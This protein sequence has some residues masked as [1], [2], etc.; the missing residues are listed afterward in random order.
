M[1]DFE[2][3]TVAVYSF[4]KKR[5]SSRSECAT[6]TPNPST[7]RTAFSSSSFDEPR[8]KI[9]PPSAGS[10]PSKHTKDLTFCSAVITSRT[11]KTSQVPSVGSKLSSLIERKTTPFVHLATYSIAVGLTLTTNATPASRRRSCAIRA[12]DRPTRT[13]DGRSAKILATI[14]CKYS[15]S[16]RRTA[17]SELYLFSTRSY[18]IANFIS[19]TAGCR[20][21]LLIFFDVTFLTK[22][23]PEKYR[24]SECSPPVITLT[25]K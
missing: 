20:I 16:W 15:S 21:S 17:S 14:D 7:T 22:L 12:T 5:A 13:T 2:P 25:R 24:Q 19:S 9:V 6:Y 4:C 3:S 18:S 10:Q 1:S 8:K 23:A 11:R